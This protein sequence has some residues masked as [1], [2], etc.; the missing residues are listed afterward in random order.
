M[1]NKT[2]LKLFV[3][4]VAAAPFIQLNAGSWNWTRPYKMPEKNV[5]TLVVIG[6]Y[7]TPRIIAD[8]IQ[9]E[10]KQPILLIP[11]DPDGKVFFLPV[12]DETMK[13]DFEDMSDFIKYLNPG[14]I[15]VLGD[16]RYVPEKYLKAIDSEQTVISITN[17]SWS[18]VAKTTTRILNLTYLDRR[19][20][21]IEEK[22]KSGDLYRP[23][24]AL[25]P[26]SV[27]P[28]TQNE[29]KGIV[30][31][32]ETEIAPEETPVAEPIDKSDV[33]KPDK[34]PVSEPKLIDETKVVP[35]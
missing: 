20:T 8:L 33:P 11:S 9:A 19:F 29:D 23:E 5:N 16:T 12:K 6:N 25:P 14:K 7:R 17:K 22:L 35:K 26:A 1:K 21:E 34:M 30:L 24:T 2:L 4:A 10:T 27:M 18:K 15:L 32:D 13:I 31:I 3:L 28:A